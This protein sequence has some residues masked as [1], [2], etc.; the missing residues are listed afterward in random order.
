LA[1]LVNSAIWKVFPPDAVVFWEGD[2][3]TNLYYLQYGPLKVLKTSA[4]GRERA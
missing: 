1:A 4:D 3:E 2:V